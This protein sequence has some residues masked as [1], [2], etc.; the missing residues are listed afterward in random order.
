MGMEKDEV[1]PEMRTE[2][3]HIFLPSI[4]SVWNALMLQQVKE[5]VGPCTPINKHLPYKLVIES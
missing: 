3:N 4:I 5:N 1:I 2:Y